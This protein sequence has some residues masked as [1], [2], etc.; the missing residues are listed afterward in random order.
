MY[1]EFVIFLFVI[2]VGGIYRLWHRKR[3]LSL[4][5]CGYFQSLI[6]R[7]GSFLEWIPVRKYY[8]LQSFFWHAGTP[9]SGLAWFSS[10]QITIEFIFEPT[11]KRYD[12]ITTMHPYVRFNLTYIDTQ[13]FIPIPAR[14][15]Y[16]WHVTRS[17]SGKAGIMQFIKLW[18]ATLSLHG[19]LYILEISRLEF[20][21]SSENEESFKNRAFR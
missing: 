13:A 8:F 16:Q 2:P 7:A 10:D 19:A 11:I 14:A 6:V 12:I 4:T 3:P 1:F 9:Q 20:V 18:S 15:F 21:R 5:V 17:C